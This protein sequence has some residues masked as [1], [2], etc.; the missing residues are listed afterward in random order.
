L[1]L[2]TYHGS[3]LGASRGNGFDPLLHPLFGLLSAAGILHLLTRRRQAWLEHRTLRALGLISFSLYLWHYPILAHGLPWAFRNAPVPLVI[4]KPFAI[5]MFIGVAVVVA[6]LS[7]LIVE[8]PFLTNARHSKAQ[9]APREPAL[10][11]AEPNET[12]GAHR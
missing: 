12:A 11:L 3:T 4:W 7:Y 8:R 5:V 6:T 2:G 10:D 9:P 1:A